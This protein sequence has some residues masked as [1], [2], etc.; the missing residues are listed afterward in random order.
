LEIIVQLSLLAAIAFGV[1]RLARAIE[2]LL[3]LLKK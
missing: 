1:H 2:S 3:E